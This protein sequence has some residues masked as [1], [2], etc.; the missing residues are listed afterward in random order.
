MTI[1]QLLVL[2]RSS[3]ALANRILASTYTVAP[4]C[5]KL[6]HDDMI[7]Y[8]HTLAVHVLRFEN[9]LLRLTRWSV[10]TLFSLPACAAA[11]SHI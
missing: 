8:M 11:G 4:F 9:G 7:L 2:Q 3:Q 6:K 5:S 1:K 10:V